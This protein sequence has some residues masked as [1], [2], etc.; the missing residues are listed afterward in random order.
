MIDLSTK[1]LY[2]LSTKLSKNLSKYIIRS[3]T[4][5]QLTKVNRI[6]IADSWYNVAVEVQNTVYPIDRYILFRKYLAA[7]LYP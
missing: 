7:A 4:G 3:E 2:Y 1:L 5:W 6:R